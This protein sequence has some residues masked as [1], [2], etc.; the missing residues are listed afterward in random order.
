MGA[1]ACGRPGGQER[2]S[3]REEE[4][5]TARERPQHEQHG[6]HGSFA[7]HWRHEETARRRSPM[8]RRAGSVPGR[9]ARKRV[10]RAASP[11]SPSHRKPK[12]ESRKPEAGSRKPESNPRSRER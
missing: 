11:A 9:P 12:A 8:R 3:A 6:I 1:R 4:S 7:W 2:R 5:A 10:V